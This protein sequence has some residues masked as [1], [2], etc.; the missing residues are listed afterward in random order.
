[1][2]TESP[3]RRTARTEAAAAAAARSGAVRSWPWGWPKRAASSAPAA[4]AV[5]IAMS[6]TPQGTGASVVC[7][8]PASTSC[9]CRQAPVHRT[10]TWRS[11]V[12][13][14]A[15]HPSSVG[16]AGVLAVSPGPR[17][18]RR[19]RFV[20]MS[21]NHCC[22][23]CAVALT[24]LTLTAATGCGGDK[25]DD[26]ARGIDNAIGATEAKPSLLD[27]ARA[28]ARTATCSAL[29]GYSSEPAES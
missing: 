22:R 27:D 15:A 2:R 21:G 6:S 9:A 17:G 5:S 14:D 10:D 16:G 26:I 13:N 20:V 1:M 11:Q 29:E 25:A 12:G 7:I 28:K 8:S 4:R 3:G 24:A 18:D 19:L 23:Y